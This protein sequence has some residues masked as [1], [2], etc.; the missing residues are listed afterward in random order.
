M[1]GNGMVAYIPIAPGVSLMTVGVTAA[2]VKISAVT[3]TE[4]GAATILV[5]SGAISVSVT[6]IKEGW[7]YDG[8]TL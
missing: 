3:S 1:S 6:I 2:V 4:E 5:V 8:G 7:N